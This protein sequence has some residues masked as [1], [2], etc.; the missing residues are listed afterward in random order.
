MDRLIDESLALVNDSARLERY[1][2]IMRRAVETVHT[3]PLFDRAYAYGLATGV[4]WKPR[5]DGFIL[6]ADVTPAR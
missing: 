5:A 6:A 4:Q 2:A 1:H 3:V